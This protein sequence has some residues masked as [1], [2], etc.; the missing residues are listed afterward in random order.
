MKTVHNDYLDA[1]FIDGASHPGVFRRIM[2]PLCMPIVVSLAVITFMGVWNDYFWPLI[3]LSD[4]HKMTLPLA[5]AQLNGQYGT[6][7]DILMAGS[8][9]SMLPIIVLYMFAQRWFKSGLQ[10]GGIK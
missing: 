1:A 10:L 3:I 8:L 4:T 9:I 5:L 2:L 7:Y 6:K